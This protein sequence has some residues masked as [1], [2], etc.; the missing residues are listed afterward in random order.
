MASYL[1]QLEVSARPSTVGGRRADAASLRPPGHRGRSDVHVG[2]RASSGPTSRTSSSGWPHVRA[3]TGK[4]LATITIRHRLG[5][6][7][8]FFERIMEWDYDD[9]PARLFIYI[10]RLPGPRRAAAQVLGRP[11]GGQV[12]GRTGA[13]TPTCVVA[14][15]SSCWPAPASG[16][17]SSPDSKT[18]PWSAT[19]T[20]TR[21]RIPVG[22]LHNDRYVPLAPDAGRPH[23]RLPEA[24]A[25]TVRSGHLLERDDG[26]PFDRRTI[27]RYVDRRGQAGR[28]RPRPSP[29]AAPHA[30][31]PVHQPGHEP[32]GHRRLA[33]A[34]L[35]GH[36]AD[37]RPHLGPD[38]RRRVLQGDRGRRG[39]YYESGEPLP[40]SVE[41]ANMRRIAA[42]HRRLLANGH[43]TR[44]A[45]LDCAFE[46]VCERCGFFETGP[47]F[48]TILKR[49]RDTPIERRSERPESALRRPHRRS[50]RR[51]V[52]VLPW[53]QPRTRGSP[54]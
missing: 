5:T 38:R 15:W 23:R 36:D 37:L 41:G 46:S 48:L 10:E 42:D 43:C 22:K 39:Q 7:R 52:S 50:R 13:A 29:S 27:H 2:G 11:D 53:T 4:P 14:S 17:A 9:A 33:R 24:R 12:H 1:D 6:V 19:A 45:L 8:T 16:S 18:T 44:P 35:H 20:T 40:A 21:L 54:M 28:G 31:H 51:P 30:R 3:R 26:Q 34:P 49:Q 47:Q 32:R 25:R